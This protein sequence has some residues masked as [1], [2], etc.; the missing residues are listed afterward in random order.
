MKLK[1][2]DKEGIPRPP[3]TGVVFQNLNVSGS[4]SAL[5]Y[6]STVGSILLEPF[7]PS[8][9]LSFAKHSPEKHILRNFDGLLKS[10]EML[11]VLGRPGSGCSTFL[12]TLCGQ[13]HGLEL[14][15]SSEIQ[16]NGVP[17]EKMHKE[18]KGEVLYNQEVDKHFPHLT[19]GQTLEFAAAARTPENRLLGLKRQQFAKHITE[20]AMAVF[21]LLHTYDTKGTSCRTDAF[22]ELMYNLIFNIRAQLATTIS[23]VFREVRGSESG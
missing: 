21:G 2:M 16:Y 4:G 11:I 7:R 15:K 9:W 5:Q 23:G 18:F 10:G 12:K 17:M 1:L 19:V 14:R 22:G 20:V 6:Q 8:G 13:L 3:S